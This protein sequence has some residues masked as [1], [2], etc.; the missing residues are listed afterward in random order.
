MSTD[1]QELVTITKDADIV[2]I[3]VLVRVDGK[4]IV[5]SNAVTQNGREAISAVKPTVRTRSAMR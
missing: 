2:Y 4:G 3:C 5:W 1:L